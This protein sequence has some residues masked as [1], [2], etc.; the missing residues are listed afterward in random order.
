METVISIFL[1][2]IGT[3]SFTKPFAVIETAQIA[4]RMPCRTIIEEITAF[5]A[6]LTADLS[7]SAIILVVLLLGLF[8]YHRKCSRKFSVSALIP[9]VLFAVLSLFVQCICVYGDLQN[10]FMN[11]PQMILSLLKIIGAIPVFYVLTDLCFSFFEISA[12]EEQDNR[13]ARMIYGRRSFILPWIIILAAWLPYLVAFYPGFVPSDGLKQLNNFFGSGNFTDYHP[14]FSSMLMGWAMMLGRK[15]GSDNLGVFL[16]TGT[17]VLIVSASMAACFP[18]FKK[19]HTP[20]WLRR[21]TLSAFALISIWPNYAYS[22]LKDSLYMAMFLLLAI[23]LIRMLADPDEFFSR[24]RYWLVM[25][26][27]LSLMYLMRHEGSAYA[28]VIAMLILLKRLRPYLGKLLVILLIPLCI[29]TT[30]NRVIR[31]AL[32]IPDSP[33]REAFSIPFMQSALTAVRHED[34]LT[35]DEVEQYERFFGDFE[36]V[37]KF[38]NLSNSD[39]LKHL[40]A[41]YPDTGYIL[42]YLKFWAELGAEYPLTYADAFFSGKNGYYAPGTMPYGG[43]YG[44]FGIEQE[45]YVNKGLFDIRYSPRTEWLR[46]TLINLTDALPRLPFIGLFYDLGLN[47]WMLMIM[48][49]FAIRKK[50]NIIPLLPCIISYVM[51]LFTPL[52]GFFRY[53]LPVL[54]CLPA[55][56]ADCISSGDVSSD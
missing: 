45:T 11:G 55:C 56:L 51:V 42:D 14:A 43:I 31:P 29:I 20:L 37:K 2:I 48:V 6:V 18:M 44:W 16:Y 40:F 5:A 12:Y 50:R 10:L 49:A 15:L 17:Q 53:M 13:F 8:L 28:V 26:F 25:V 23:Q 9:G 1:S 47:A 34:E 4:G 39:N 52:N 54:I 35:A 41:L 46:N 32:Q 24:K 36:K 22:L 33:K 3:W 21:L 30:F 19:L 38:C 27:S 7:E